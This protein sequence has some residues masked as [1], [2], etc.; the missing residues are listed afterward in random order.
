MCW[1][2]LNYVIF[3]VQC[4]EYIRILMHLN[5]DTYTLFTLLWITAKINRR[6][7]TMNIWPID[8]LNAAS[9]AVDSGC[10]FSVTAR[11]WSGQTA[12]SLTT[13]GMTKDIIDDAVLWRLPTSP[14]V[15]TPHASRKRPQPVTCASWTLGH[16]QPSRAWK[17]RWKW[18][19]GSPSHWKHLQKTGVLQFLTFGVQVGVNNI[20]NGNLSSA[21]TADQSAEQ[22]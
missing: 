3:C 11:P 7:T 20:N 12:P 13:D 9:T 4:F 19:R 15:S 22:T 16:V 17:T 18:G 8:T 5:T 1:F 2:W 6:M 10:H 14:S 21:N